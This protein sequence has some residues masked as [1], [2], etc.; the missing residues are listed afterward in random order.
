MGK[1]RVTYVFHTPLYQDED[2]DKLLV[3][4]HLSRFCTVLIV[5]NINNLTGDTF[6]LVFGH[7]H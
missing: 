5:F 6:S 2:L 7:H 1:P 4:F 3:C